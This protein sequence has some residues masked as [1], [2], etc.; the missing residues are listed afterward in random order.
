[1]VLWRCVVSGMQSQGNS[2]TRARLEIS[3]WPMDSEQLPEWASDHDAL[4][5]T[6]ILAMAV[7]KVCAS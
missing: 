2:P 7:Y 4:Q 1:M 5:P 6:L 3:C